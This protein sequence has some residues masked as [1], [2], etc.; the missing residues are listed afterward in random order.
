[1]T[2]G[3]L[4][5]VV[6]GEVTWSAMD[7]FSW[8]WIELLEWLALNW[9][10]IQYEDGLPFDTDPRT[11]ED[12]R[13]F[14]ERESLYA[15]TAVADEIEMT[16]WEFLESHDLNRALQ[17]ASYRSVVIWREGLLGHVLTASKH[18]VMPWKELK[19]LLSELGD[20]IAGRLKGF[21]S[22]DARGVAA[23]AN[24]LTR[25]KIP[26]R[27]ALE[28]A[29]GFSGT[30][31][32]K[33]LES[34][35]LE[36]AVSNEEEFMQTDEFLAV[37]RMTAALPTSVVAEILSELT[38]VNRL[39]A[40][41][42]EGVSAHVLQAVT[43]VERS[44]AYEEGY[45]AASALRDYMRL[46][47]SLPFDPR[48]WLQ[49]F[50]IDYRELSLRTKLIDAIA[51]W[52]RRRGPAVLVNTDGQ[53]AQSRSG[54]NTSIAHEIGHILLDRGGALPA[55]EVLGGRVNPAIEARARAF[56]VELLLPRRVAGEAMSAADSLN[57][58][59]AVRSLVSRYRVSQE[60]VAWQARNS[61]MQFGEDVTDYLKTL[62]TTPEL[63]NR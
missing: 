44:K 1:M 37:A 30:R 17:G 28:I 20:I 54:R 19:G 41:G 7:G 13:R 21:D 4:E 35:D 34:F 51:C 48:D 14:V 25:D 9:S 29:S 5:V 52:G 46:D 31:L 38:S 60:V 39:S 61:S 55:A 11:T 49:S 59:H 42:L 27:S 18:A 23:R 45:A 62:V 16:L 36:S 40:P 6:A 47:S 50:N 58:R 56:A 53:H 26:R 15:S 32:N 33:L 2:D 8:T 57:A 43:N 10:R 22:L 24:W 3:T 63:F 12:L